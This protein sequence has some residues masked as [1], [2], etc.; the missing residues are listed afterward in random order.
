M[1]KFN[2]PLFRQCRTDLSVFTRAVINRTFPFLPA[3]E[4]GIDSQSY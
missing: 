2:S 1:D 4:G 3:T